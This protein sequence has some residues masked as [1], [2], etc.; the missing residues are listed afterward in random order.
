MG[1]TA[2]KARDKASNRGA[3]ASEVVTA[4]SRADAYKI[5]LTNENRIGSGTFAD[6]YKIQK[7]DT[8]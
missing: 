3:R 7:K 4:P 8:K 1:N 2:E 6:V 5:D